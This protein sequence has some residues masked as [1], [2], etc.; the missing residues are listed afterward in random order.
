MNNYFV[1]NFLENFNELLLP[2]HTPMLSFSP[3]QLLVAG[4]AIFAIAFLDGLIKNEWG[5]YL[6]L[7]S[8]LIIFAW[9]FGLQS[10]TV[11]LALIFILLV[12]RLQLVLKIFSS[13]GLV[14][15]GLN[16]HDWMNGSFILLMT[17]IFMFYQFSSKTS[18]RLKVKLIIFGALSWSAA[19]VLSYE[20]AL[21]YFPQLSLG[22]LFFFLTGQRVLY[23]YLDVRDLKEISFRES[24]FFF[25]QVYDLLGGSWWGRVGPGPREFTTS[26]KDSATT[27]YRSGFKLLFF[28][29]V[30]L[31][32]LTL[33]VSGQFDELS[34]LPSSSKFDL[35]GRII[36]WFLGVFSATTALYHFKVGLFNI[37]GYSIEPCTHHIWKSKSLSD[38]WLRYSRYYMKLILRLFYLPI[39]LRL[40]T[41]S[42]VARKAL[43]LAL[44]IMIGQ[45]LIYS[46]TRLISNNVQIYLS[47]GYFVILSVAIFINSE[48][49]P[50]SE[51]RNER[52][53]LKGFGFFAGI[54]VFYSLI[55]LFITADPNMIRLLSVLVGIES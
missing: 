37:A 49:I 35:L 38:F 41:L 50:Q 21:R 47:L 13:L 3:V 46:M 54:W 30:Y 17:L 15:L 36:L 9:L 6:S 22:I 51:Q 12:P 18:A 14:I 26:R 42:L 27:G 29:L 11:Y 10:L 55:H 20:N 4:V 5:R 43:S 7:F 25:T 52:M 48:M 53:T 2:M 39:F 16:I 44:S 8:F 33:L 28:S 31:S 1:Q 34:Y 24:L 19:I 45:F 32:I 40:K 23:Y